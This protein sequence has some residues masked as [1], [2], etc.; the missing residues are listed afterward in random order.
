MGCLKAF[1]ENKYCQRPKRNIKCNCVLKHK[2]RQLQAA[3]W[4]S[5][6]WNVKISIPQISA[7]PILL[8]W[9]KEL[10][11]MT[12]EKP[13]HVSAETISWLLRIIH[14]QPCTVISVN[15]WCFVPL[16]PCKLA[17]VHGE[18]CGLNSDIVSGKSY[19]CCFISL[20]LIFQ[21]FQHH[22]WNYIQVIMLVWQLG[23]ILV[24]REH[25]HLFQ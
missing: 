21:C 13:Q 15:W 3:F 10:Q 1:I 18:V 11:K 5:R 19:C 23:P 6:C 17:T 12:L 22:K 24:L 4:C 20:F 8:P 2:L 16:K 14:C 25:I 9:L 7:Y